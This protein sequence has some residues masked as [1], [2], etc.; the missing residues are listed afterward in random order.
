[1]AMYRRLK[2]RFKRSAARLRSGY[3]R[4]RYGRSGYRKRRSRV[5]RSRA[6]AAY[7]GVPYRRFRKR[8]FFRSAGYAPPRDFKNMHILGM[9]APIFALI[10]G[11]L[12][13]FFVQP[14]K[15][16]VHSIFKKK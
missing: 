7:H 3:G 14:F 5:R 15:D 13:Y 12:A 16:L 8:G 6:S 11:V 2:R 10:V 1:M 9:S 4:I